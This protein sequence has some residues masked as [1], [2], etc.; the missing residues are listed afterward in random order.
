[1]LKYNTVITRYSF[2]LMEENYAFWQLSNNSN[3]ILQLD[4]A[5][6]VLL[7]LAVTV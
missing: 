6:F 3:L 1:M 4:G 2:L 7:T 5:P